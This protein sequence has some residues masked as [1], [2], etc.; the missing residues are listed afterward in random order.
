MGAPEKSGTLLPP[1]REAVVAPGVVSG[2]GSQRRK[3]AGVLLTLVPIARAWVSRPVH[4]CRHI[5][6]NHKI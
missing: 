5:M 3:G 4:G 1:M 6:A 2:A